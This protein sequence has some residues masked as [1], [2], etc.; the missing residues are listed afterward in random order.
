MVLLTVVAMMVVMAG[1]TSA[2]AAFSRS[3]C[4]LQPQAEREEDGTVLLIPGEGTN[5]GKVCT[6]RPFVAS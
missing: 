5:E 2:K 4:V 3:A 6:G 1:T